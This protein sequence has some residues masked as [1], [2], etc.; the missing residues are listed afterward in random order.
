MK[1]PSNAP[2]IESVGCRVKLRGR[3]YLGYITGI[4]PKSKWTNVAWDWECYANPIKDKEGRD[5]YPVW[6]YVSLEELE[7]YEEH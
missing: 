5:W 6:G 4:N 2:T 7:L 3:P 1:R